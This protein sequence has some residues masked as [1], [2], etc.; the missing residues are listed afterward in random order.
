MR[1]A[2]RRL[3]GQMAQMKIWTENDLHRLHQ[4]PQSHP[5]TRHPVLHHQK[6]VMT[7]VPL[8]TA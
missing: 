5:R 8:N 7:S 3:R 2:P 6:D 4:N 1:E